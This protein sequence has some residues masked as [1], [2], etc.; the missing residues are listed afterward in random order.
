[1]TAGLQESVTY[2]VKAISEIEMSSDVLKNK[3][4]GFLT[5]SGIF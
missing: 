2:M 3:I 1:M 5:R 4:F